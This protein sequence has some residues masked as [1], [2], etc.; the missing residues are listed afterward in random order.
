MNS[1]GS[2]G[3]FGS[4]RVQVGPAMVWA[5]FG[6]GLRI[7]CP[8]RPIAS[9]DLGLEITTGDGS[10]QGYSNPSFEF[11]AFYFLPLCHRLSL[12]N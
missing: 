9:L 3:F 7:W 4:G 11:S 12:L 2:P 1:L 10:P 8:G 5:G 6:P